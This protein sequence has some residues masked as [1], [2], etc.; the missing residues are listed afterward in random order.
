MT[1]RNATMP[2]DTAHNRTGDIVAQIASVLRAEMEKQ[3]LGFNELARRAELR[4]SVIHA[5]LTGE[6][7]NPGV[8]TVIAIL[9]ALGK[10]LTWLDREQKK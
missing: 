10:S 5:V 2:P 3:G 4:P 8:L 6:T 7:P 1:K 9:K